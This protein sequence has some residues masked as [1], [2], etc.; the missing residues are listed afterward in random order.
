MLDFSPTGVARLKGTG[1]SLRTILIPGLLEA[2]FLLFHC[3]DHDAT[4]T[5]WNDKMRNRVR[6]DGGLTRN[7]R[8]P[9]ISWGHCYDDQDSSN[10]IL[11]SNVDKLDTYTS[12]PLSAHCQYS[13]ASYL[14]QHRSYLLPRNLHLNFPYSTCS[15]STYTSPHTLSHSLSSTHSSAPSLT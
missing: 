4:L 11:H 1:P 14:Q 8:F 3:Y 9:S 12:G 7:G 13:L 2:I 6:L 15:P 10:Y 5:I